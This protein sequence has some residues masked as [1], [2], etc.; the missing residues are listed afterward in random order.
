MWGSDKDLLKQKQKQK[1]VSRCRLWLRVSSWRRRALPAYHSRSD[2]ERI[3]ESQFHLTPNLLSFSCHIAPALLSHNA[4][5]ASASVC[6]RICDALRQW[7]AVWSF[8]SFDPGTGS[9]LPRICHVKFFLS[10][11][12]Q[13]MHYGCVH[14]FGGVRRLL[15]SLNWCIYCGT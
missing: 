15:Y 10:Q 5:R 9:N 11:T 8:P 13:Q 14:Y 1:Q 2:L 7:S 6:H 12:E 4:F 3:S